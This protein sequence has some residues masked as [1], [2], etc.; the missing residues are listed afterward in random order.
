MKITDLFEGRVATWSN[1]ITVVRVILAPVVT[2]AL[3]YEKTTGELW[4]GKLALAVY[5]IIA[6]SDFIDGILA[7][8]LHQVSR[9]GQFLDPLADKCVIFVIA[10][11][12]YFF[13][14][15]P[16]WMIIVI[17]IRDIFHVIVGFYLFYKHDIQVR[18]SFA[19]K[20]MVVV[21]GVCGLI[22]IINPSTTIAGYT[23]QQIS[24][25]VV[26]LLVILSSVANWRIYSKIYF[27]GKR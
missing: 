22:F 1:L 4:Y 17:L 9:L 5:I 19:G 12:L 8:M 24:L 18:P 25:L 16:L 21:M 27:T 7:R 11:T 20:C 23:L 2:G 10:T 13:R 6:I 26:L 15:F 14:Q 3:Y